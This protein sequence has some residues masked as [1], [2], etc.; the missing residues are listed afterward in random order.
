MKLSGVDTA[1][2]NQKGSTGVF[3]ALI[4]SDGKRTIFVN[5]GVASALDSK[6][7]PSV[8]FEAETILHVD[9]FLAASSGK[10][11]ALIRRALENGARIS[12]DVGG[13][14]IAI[15]NRDLFKKTIGQASW[16]FMNEDEY[17]AL[18]EKSVDESL[19]DFSS[20][21]QATL[22]VK[23]AEVG[24]V[25]FSGGNLVQSPVRKI[26]PLDET[27]AGDAFAAGYL[28]AALSGASLPQCMRLANRVAEHVIQVPGMQFNRA[29]LHNIA[30]EFL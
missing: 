5:S 22:I 2:Q 9:G 24:A 21:T 23:R 4:Q 17:C 30:A 7:M 8:F 11:D 13:K 15:K 12:F 18:S 1:L 3:C 25:C 19:S 29:I 28:F 26:N 10:F 16:V 6:A 27:G 20:G 14:G